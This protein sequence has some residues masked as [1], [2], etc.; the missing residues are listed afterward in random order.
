MGQ[1]EHDDDEIVLLTDEEL[2]LLT[3][4][5]LAEYM[6]LLEA[7]RRAD[8][9]EW[10]PQPKQALATQLAGRAIETLY[11]GAAGGGKTEWLL[12]YALEQML[13]HPFNNG[14]I[15]RRVFPSLVKTLIPRS[16]RVYPAYGG[17]WN[18]QNH[19]WTFPNGSV[20]TFGSL[21]YEDSVFDYQ[22]TEYGLIA[23]EEI[24]EFTESQYLEML[25]RLR[26]GG[27]GIRSHVVA[28]TNPG[29]RGHLWVKRRWV[30]P[31][32]IDFDGAAPLPFEVWQPKPTDSNPEPT[33]RVF[34][35]ATLAD[36]PRLLARD[37][38]YVN[39]IR[40][41]A[42]TNKGRAKAMETGDWDAIDAIEGALWTQ[43]DLNAG[44]RTALQLA[45]LGVVERVVALDPSDGNEDGKGDSFGVAVCSKGMDG[46]GYVEYVEGWR[47]APLQMAKNIIALYHRVGADCIVIEKNH[48]GVWLPAVLRQIDRYVN[49]RVVWASEGKVTRAR[50]VAALFEPVEDIEGDPYR[51]HL[52][53]EHEEFE[54]QATTYTGQPKEASPNELDAVVW[55]LTHLLLKG[56]PMPDGAGYDDQRLHGRR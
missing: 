34:V 55:G 29:G 22:G 13:A 51:A 32:P 41:L 47:A 2:D 20:L 37:P 33:S 15:F 45:Q 35:P 16:K 53:G 17:V 28:T 21:Q 3:D 24:T 23:F 10:E 56:R 31:K 25:V 14:V 7:F 46:A 5:E 49:I 27:A 48:G 39:K 36:N 6:H 18:G 9:E 40:A 1:P 54:G 42:G 19:D 38:S 4:E 11:G 44:R 12:H 50:P 26:P 8:G 43:A 52:V 30:K